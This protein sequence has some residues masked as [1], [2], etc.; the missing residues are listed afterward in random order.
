MCLSKR[1]NFCVH[2]A[3]PSTTMPCFCEICIGKAFPVESVNR[4]VHRRNMHIYN[5]NQACFLGVDPA[6]LATPRLHG[7]IYDVAVGR[8]YDDAHNATEKCVVKWVRRDHLH[9]CSMNHFYFTKQ[10]CRMA[11]EIIAA[12]V[13]QICTRGYS[14][15]LNKPKVWKCDWRETLGE[16]KVLVEPYLSNFE[17]FNSNSGWM[18]DSSRTYEKVAQ[19]LSHFSYAWSHHK[20]LLCDLQGT[21]EHNTIIFTDPSIHSLHAGQYGCTDRGRRGIRNFMEFHKCNRMCSHLPLPRDRKVFF[22]PTEATQSSC[23]E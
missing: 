14:I 6:F 5:A 12:F 20:L 10:T 2:N 18:C 8:N 1:A 22:H 11:A 4:H 13:R 21:V 16:R 7:T 19:A 17:K 23:L 15:L 3:T 9:Q